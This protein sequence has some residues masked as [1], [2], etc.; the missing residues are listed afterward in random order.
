MNKKHIRIKI[1]CLLLLALPLAFISCGYQEQKAAKQVKNNNFY[2]TCSMHP[3][4]HEDNPGNCPICGM[5]LIRAEQA[6]SDQQ[7]SIKLTTSQLQLAGINTDTVRE[8]YTGEQKIVSGTITADETASG[9]LSARLSGRIQKLLIR[10]VGETV[11]VG[12]TVYSIYSE[13]LQEAEKEYL[14][15]REQQQKLHNPDV[16]YQALI[17]AAENKLRLWGMTTGQINNLVKAGRVSAATAIVSTVGGTV[18]EI[19]VHEGDYVTEGMTILK[20]QRLGSLWVEA[21]LYGGEAQ[22]LHTGQ[23]VNVS[24]PDL[25]GQTVQGKVVFI[26]PE[27]SDA[28]KVD[29]VRI[30]IVNPQGLLRPGMQANILIEDG[31]RTLA[32]PVSAVITSAKGSLV[33]VKN[34]DG[35][36]SARM[37][38]LGN[39]NN[40]YIQLIA[41]LSPGDVVVTTGAYLLTS[42]SIFRNGSDQGSMAGMKM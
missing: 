14:L 40:S 38:E 20:T 42:E 29:L 23:V 37:V 12:E 5:K 31:S 18:S 39:R 27:L 32:V 1:T 2:Y 22:K 41:G 36:F 4:V 17:S 24:L 16:D 6:A 26:N 25:S 30:N 21:Q 28:S 19:N 13:D 8:A 33:W 3:Q 34:R 15:A 10:T 35:S 9:E 11:K 7:N